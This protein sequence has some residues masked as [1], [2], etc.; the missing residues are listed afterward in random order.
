MKAVVQTNFDDSVSAYDAYERQTG[1]FTALARLLAAEMSARVDGP[2]AAVLDA[3][4]GTG[5]STRVFAD[6]AQRTVALD[7]SREMVRELESAPRVEGDFDHLPFVD[8]T[9]DGV[10]FTASLFLVPDPA[11]AVR[12]AVRVLRPEGVVGAVAPLGWVDADGRDVFADLERES[13]SPTGADAVEAA[14]ADEFTV[15]TGTWRFSTTAADVR[16][17]HAI[18][19]MAARLYPTLDADERV[20]KARDLLDGLEGTVEQRWRWIVG[21]AE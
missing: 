3:G 13:R 5:V 1:R 18:P 11:V 17:F 7:L 21:V 2:F 10:A 16:R 19:A 20:A 14:L 4:A 12:E 9:F 15:T 6:R 8:G